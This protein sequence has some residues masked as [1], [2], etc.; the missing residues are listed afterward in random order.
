MP[1]GAGRPR[2]L[3]LFHPFSQQTRNE[4]KKERERRKGRESGVRWRA[5]GRTAWAD[6]VLDSGE[7]A[8]DVRLE[9]GGEGSRDEEGRAAKLAPALR[10]EEKRSK[11]ARTRKREE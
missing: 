6:G 5:A 2:S 8:D 3:P 1:S 11:G 9:Q 10:R 4:R 7:V